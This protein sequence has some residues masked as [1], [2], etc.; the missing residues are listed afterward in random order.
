MLGELVRAVL[1]RALESKLTAHLAYE[2]GSRGSQDGNARNWTGVAN[3]IKSPAF[4]GRGHTVSGTAAESRQATNTIV[5]APAITRLSCVRPGHAAG[6]ARPW[7][8]VKQPTVRTDRPC[9]TH[10]R[11]LCV[12]G[13]RN[14]T[15]Y[16]ATR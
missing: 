10:A 15:V 16:S 12:R 2:K 7:P 9:S 6:A 1:E 8:S 11:P 13:H 3:D 14:I 5:K 4:P